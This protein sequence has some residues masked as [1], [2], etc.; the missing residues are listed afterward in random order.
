MVYTGAVFNSSGTYV[1]QVDIAYNSTLW[2]NAPQAGTRQVSQAVISVPNTSTIRSARVRL[3]GGTGS[4][5]V[6]I[7][8]VYLGR[9]P[10]QITPETVSTYIANLSVDTLQIANQAVTVPLSIQYS[11]MASYTT[12]SVETAVNTAA[13]A[14]DFGTNAP[15]KV[16]CLAQVDLQ[17]SGLGSDYAA[18]QLRLRYN[19]TNS[20]TISSSTVVEA[21]QVND[22]KG[23]APALSL[24][25]TINGWTGA[26]YFFLTIEVTAESGSATG[27]WKASD[28]N[29]SLLGARR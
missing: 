12:N 14:A 2:G 26:R 25:R 1:D 8:N 19:T 5:Y 29:I 4:S 27:W 17:A 20:T 3:K 18:A 15:D 7:W 13:L 10:S 11:A 24:S 23:A 22:R 21:V 28:A 16:I 6:N 9:S